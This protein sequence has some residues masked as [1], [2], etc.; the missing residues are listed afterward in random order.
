MGEI[1]DET[2]AAITGQDPADVPDVEDYEDDYVAGNRRHDKIRRKDQK[3]TADTHSPVYAKLKPPITKYKKPTTPPSLPPWYTQ[4]YGNVNQQFSNSV[5]YHNPHRQADDYHSQSRNREVVHSHSYTRNSHEGNHITPENSHYYK[6]E[7]Y[8]SPLVRYTTERERFIT[9]AP[10]MQSIL[11]S[12]KEGKLDDPRNP[13]Y[14][15]VPQHQNPPT[16][17]NELHSTK[18]DDHPKQPAKPEKKFVPEVVAESN[19]LS[20]SD[21]VEAAKPDVDKYIDPE[22]SVFALKNNPAIA[23]LL[24][25]AYFSN[26]ELNHPNNTANSVL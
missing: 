10:I 11:S 5:E 14:R 4:S 6:S 21:V 8:H 19:A 20:E 12:E 16:K 25:T 15:Y 18:R 2:A 3:E 17:Y 26:L 24:R 9:P 1:D 7:Q 13:N 22:L 23:E